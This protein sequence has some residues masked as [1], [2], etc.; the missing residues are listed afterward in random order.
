MSREGYRMDEASVD[1]VRELKN[2]VPS[3]VCQVR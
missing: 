3:N 2:M 1:L